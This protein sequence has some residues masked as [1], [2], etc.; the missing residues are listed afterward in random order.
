MTA[1]WW[2]AGRC[3]GGEQV[4]GFDGPATLLAPYGE[5]AGITH[6]ARVRVERR[7][8]GLRPDASWRGRV[9]DAFG[10]AQD[11][12]PA[13]RPGRRTYAVQAPPPPAGQR[14]GLGD[15][16]SLGV[17]ARSLRTG[18]CAGQRLGIFAGSGWA[19]RACSPCWR[20]RRPPM[21]W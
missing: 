15:R 3:H 4:V 14:A 20:K 19:S 8:D 6:G 5:I 16:L 12:G 21:S 18:A 17:R 10:N 1:A 7:L 2:A 11:G 13:L 9:V